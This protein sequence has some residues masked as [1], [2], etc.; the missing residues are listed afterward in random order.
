MGERLRT[1]VQAVLTFRTVLQLLRRPV[2]R[3]NDRHREMNEVRPEALVRVHRVTYCVLFPLDRFGIAQYDC[4][5]WLEGEEATLPMV[6]IV[7]VSASLLAVPWPASP[8]EDEAEANS[9]AIEESRTGFGVPPLD[10][11]LLV[12]RL[13]VLV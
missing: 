11:G 9:H 12:V 8:L 1:Q 4:L 3:R 5:V 10:Q 2:Q 13:F 7:G 6:D